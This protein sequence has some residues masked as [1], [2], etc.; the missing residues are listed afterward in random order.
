VVERVEDRGEPEFELLG[1]AVAG[2][3]ECP[4]TVSAR[5]DEMARRCCRACTGIA[6]TSAALLMA[7]KGRSSPGTRTGRCRRREPKM[8]GSPS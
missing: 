6:A 5:Y 3:G 4:R 8:R 7:S 2:L 1:E